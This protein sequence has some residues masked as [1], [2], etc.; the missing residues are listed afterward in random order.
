MYVSIDK[1]LISFGIAAVFYL[2]V[3]RERLKKAFSHFEY[4]HRQH[5]TASR[6]TRCPRATDRGAQSYAIM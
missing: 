1:Q 2:L 6:T 4:L 3:P 5:N